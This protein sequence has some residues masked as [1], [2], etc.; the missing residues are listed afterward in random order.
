MRFKLTG[1]KN[2][3]KVQKIVLGVNIIF[4][5]SL[6]FAYLAAYVSPV[7][8]WPFAFFGLAYPVLLLINL[9]FILYWSLKKSWMLLISAVMV[10]VGA[11]QIGRLMQITISSGPV[12][13]KNN[14]QV[15]VLSYNVRLFD[16][17]DWSKN[18][19]TKNKIFKVIDRIDADIVCF[20]EFFVI[21]QKGRFETRDT[22]VQFLRSKNYHERYTHH[23]KGGQHFGLATFT[24][25][26][27]VNRGWISF[28]N[29]KNNSCIYTDMKIGDDTVRVF[30]AHLASIRFQREDYQIVGDKKSNKR[31]HPKKG[32]EQKIVPRLKN[33]FIKRAAQVEEL[34]KHIRKSPY[35]VILCGDFNDTP[36]SY[37]YNTIASQLT[38][39]FV[40]SGNGFGRTYIGSFPSYRID[41]I[42]HSKS[43]HSYHFETHP[44]ELSDHRPIS[45]TV[46]ILK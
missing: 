19:T 11:N 42:F 29:D 43:L 39:A 44:E 13:E 24:I 40:K 9:I 12:D 8:F 23:L 32:L 34:A 15:K 22:L 33:A 27:I 2:L 36:I 4:A 3:S 37:S 26:P 28:N 17:Y 45:C 31:R 16:L 1:F 41:Y 20:Q 14:E 38:D 10:V 21:D 35:R 30:N 7:S 6:L 5:F 18:K 46:E 25:Y